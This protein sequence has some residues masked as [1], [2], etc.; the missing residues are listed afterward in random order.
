[1]ASHMRIKMTDPQTSEVYYWTVCSHSA[2]SIGE[3]GRK[4]HRVTGWLFTSHDGC[5]RFSEGPWRELVPMFRLVA[6]NY[7]L[8]C[9]LS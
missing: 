9:N 2:I 6:E 1:M 5:E 3:S 4:S 7:G 8:T